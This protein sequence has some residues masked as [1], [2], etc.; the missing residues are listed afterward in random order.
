M[1]ILFILN[2]KS[3]TEPVD[4]YE[5]QSRIAAYFPDASFCITQMPGHATKLAQDAVKEH[6]EA[7]VAMGGDGTVNEVVKALVGTQTALGIVPRGSG[8]GFA[9]EL[10]LVGPIQKTLEKLKNSSV[11]FCD[12]GLANEEPFLN[13]AGVGLEAAIAW[14]FAAQKKRGMVPYF[15][16][17]AKT[18]FTYK[19]PVLRVTLNGQQ[20][21]WAPLSLVLANNRQYGSRFII[22]PRAAIADGKLDLVIIKD[23]SKLKLLWAL[24]SFFSGKEPPLRVTASTTL[25]QAVIEAEGEIP[26]HIDGEPRKA[27]GR[28]EIGLRPLALRL[29]VP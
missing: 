17:A 15:T 29:L 22:A 25:Q 13:V 12:V 8:N 20:H 9:R 24:P 27:Q 23:V 21:R 4:S 6:F 26:Y 3:G 2:P 7:V 18:L 1:K 10:G 28:L 11:Q 16:L 14:K 5:I 19:P